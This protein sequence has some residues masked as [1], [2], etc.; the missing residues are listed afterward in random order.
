MGISQI[1]P[2]YAKYVT[3]NIL[4]MIGLSLYILADTFFIARG[5][6]PDGLTA[7]NL[8]IPV[9]SFINGLGLMIGMGGATRYSISKGNHDTDSR[10][11]IFSQAFCFMA[12][13]AALFFLGGLFLPDQLSALLGADESVLPHT[14]IYLRII[15]LFTPLFMCNNLLLCFVRNDGSPSLSMCAMLTGSFSNIILDYIFIFPLQWGMFGA[16]FATGLAPAISM[17]VLSVHFLKKRNQFRL[18]PS[19]I[20]LRRLIDISALG[21]SSL[22]TEV[23]SGVVMIIFNMLILDIGGN[24]GVAA[25]GIIANIALVLTSIYTGISQGI[26]PIISGLF[27]K[28]ESRGILAVRR[29]ALCTSLLFSLVSYLCTYFFAVPIVDLFNKEHDLRLEEIAVGG[30]HIYFLAFFFIGINIMTAALLSS[31]DRPRSAFILSALRGFLLV[32][33]AAFLLCALLGLKG[34]WL[35]LPVTEGIVALAAIF[36]NRRLTL[37]PTAS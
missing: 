3:A 30:M 25:Y 36:M 27:G 5:I 23:S 2:A 20:R 28:K 11:F 10:R 37:F 22:I 12:V 32:I 6:G 9:Y 4:G 18:Y 16:A 8:A 24:L 14:S 7:L 34:I 1:L 26:Q 33:P 21:V 19:P 31:V 29:L 13:L 15:L 17:L 35:T